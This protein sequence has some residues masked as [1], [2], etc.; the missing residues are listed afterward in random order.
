MYRPFAENGAS[1]AQHRAV[2]QQRGIGLVQVFQPAWSPSALPAHGALPSGRSGPADITP[3]R[4]RQQA[5]PKVASSSRPAVAARHSRGLN[6]R[7]ALRQS[8]PQ[9]APLVAEI[10]THQPYAQSAHQ[11][12]TSHPPEVRPSRKAHDT[13]NRR[14]LSSE[15][16]MVAV[17]RKYRKA[18]PFHAAHQGLVRVTSVQPRSRTARDCADPTDYGVTAP[19]AA[20]WIGRRTSSFQSG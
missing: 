5:P 3:P 18:A 6:S 1:P 16:T 20:G 8:L 19:D 4:R 11:V 17:A 2:R 13:S 15:R 9:R 10:F 7:S 14:S 12:E